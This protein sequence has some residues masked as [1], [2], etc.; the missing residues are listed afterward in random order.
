M[1]VNPHV[2]WRI[3]ASDLSATCFLHQ[4]VEGGIGGRIAATDPVTVE[5]PDIAG[6]ADYRYGG[7]GVGLLGAVG[8]GVLKRVDGQVD[9][10]VD[11]SP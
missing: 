6:L 3:D 1:P 2:E 7:G 11:R 5:L 4:H 10:V 9:F 8:T